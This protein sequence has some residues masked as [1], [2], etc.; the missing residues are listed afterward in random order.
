MHSEEPEDWAI[1]RP[2]RL[3]RV[4]AARGVDHDIA[5]IYGRIFENSLAQ[6]RLLQLD[7]IDIR[8]FEWRTTA[9]DDDLMT[10]LLA[11]FSRQSRQVT[12]IASH[13]ATLLIHIF[14]QFRSSRSPLRVSR[15]L[16][17]R[18]S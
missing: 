8:R 13:P 12:R 1:H 17:P 9:F 15:V 18:G 7:R 11:P 5:G 4:G 2:A 6:H 3:A 10:L 16:I 14:R